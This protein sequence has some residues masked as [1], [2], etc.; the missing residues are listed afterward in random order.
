VTTIDTGFDPSQ[1]VVVNLRQE[2]GQ[3]AV[4]LEQQYAIVARE[5]AGDPEV[6]RMA[7]GVTAPFLSG[8]AV[9]IEVPGLDSLPPETGGAIYVNAVTPDF[10]STMGLRLTRGRIFDARDA[11]TPVAVVSEQF[12]KTI[13]P[14]ANPLGK[15][16]HIYARSTPCRTV[17]GVIADPKR[18]KLGEEPVSQFFVPLDAAPEVASARLLFVRVRRHADEAARYIVEAVERA[19]PHA[20]YPRVQPLSELVSAQQRPWAL[21]AALFVAFGL[22]A[23]CISQLGLYNI[24]F[25]DVKA[26]ERELAIRVTLG[27]NLRDLVTSVLFRTGGAVAVGLVLG[28]AAAYW[29]GLRVEPLLFRTSGVDPE[30]D[31]LIAVVTLGVAAAAAAAPLWRAWRVQPA[32]V[33]RE[34]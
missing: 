24:I 23:L 26:R 27:A 18:D 2:R 5:L 21:G 25:H 8:V 11:R 4:V 1:V 31:V 32:V 13:W 6:E 17:V 30:I 33:L 19:L 20:T 10:F 7:I 14:E 28:L 9:R 34:D 15:C 16:L 3:S 12:A 29:M 22:L